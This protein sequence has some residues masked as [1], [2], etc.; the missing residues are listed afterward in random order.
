MTLWKIIEDFPNYEV[1]EDSK[2]RNKITKKELTQ[3][4][5]KAMPVYGF[6]KIV[7]KVTKE[8][9]LYLQKP[10]LKIQIIIKKLIIK[11]ETNFS[12]ILVT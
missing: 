12:I 11:M 4:I 8:Y 2:V 10:L 3:S 6:I 5:K 9:I 7:K 1:N